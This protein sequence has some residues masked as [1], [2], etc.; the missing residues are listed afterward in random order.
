MVKR[1]SSPMY[2]WLRFLSEC[3]GEDKELLNRLFMKLNRTHKLQIMIL[4]DQGA[5]HEKIKEKLEK[6]C[7]EQAIDAL[8]KE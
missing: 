5:S 3:K 4:I 7:A 2:S 1:S 6:Y 8:A